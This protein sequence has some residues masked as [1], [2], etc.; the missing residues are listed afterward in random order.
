[1]KTTELLKILSSETKA[2]I[3]TKLYSC[4]REDS[5]NEICEEFDLKQSNVSKHLMDLRRLKIVEFTKNGKESTYKLC[6]EFLKK[7]EGLLLAI[8]ENSNCDEFNYT[9]N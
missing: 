3:I 1:M 2:R 5:V 4:T 9:T 6:D 8:I 7:N